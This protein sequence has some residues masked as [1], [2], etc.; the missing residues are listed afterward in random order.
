M[1]KVGVVDFISKYKGIKLVGVKDW[2]NPISSLKGNINDGLKGKKVRLFLNDKGKVEKLEL[3]SEDKVP[4]KTTTKLYLERREDRITR[5]AS[6]NS[7]IELL[8][9]FVSLRDIKEDLTIDELVNIV[10][11]T[12]EKIEEFNN[13]VMKK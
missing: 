2:F 11:K 8:K 9:L 1:E 6:V 12:A 13:E 4:E 10:L 5:M 7:A 3:I